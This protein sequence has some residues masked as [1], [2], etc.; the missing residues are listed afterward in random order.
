[1]HS[2]RA[3]ITRP[4]TDIRVFSNVEKEKVRRLFGEVKS[5]RRN[6]VHEIEAMQ[7]RMHMV[8]KFL[9][10]GWLQLMMNV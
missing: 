6:Y 5:K 3:W 1:M 9:N 4:R 8:F 7:V 10:L 2:Y